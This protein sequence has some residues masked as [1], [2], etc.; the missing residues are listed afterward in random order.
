MLAVA[1]LGYSTGG[2]CHKNLFAAGIMPQPCPYSPPRSM[3]K[4]DWA[5]LVIPKHHLAYDDSDGGGDDDR[6][7]DFLGFHCMLPP[8]FLTQG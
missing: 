7:D 1:H 6:I 3:P 4:T 2:R 5:D 8:A